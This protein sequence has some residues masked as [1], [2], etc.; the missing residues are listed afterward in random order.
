MIIGKEYISEMRKALD[1]FCDEI[2]RFH[3]EQG[4]NWANDSPAAKEVGGSKGA[5]SLVTAWSHAALLIESGSE[6]LSSFIHAV[7]EPVQPIACWT[8]VRSMLEPCSVSLWLLDPDIDARTRIGRS[9][10]IRY[11]GMD[12]FLKY[13]R[14]TSKDDGFLQP[15][16]DRIREVE[17]EA[18]DLGYPKIRDKT[19]KRRIGIGQRMPSA[20]ELIRMMLNQESMYR[21]LS[22][23]AHGHNWAIRELSYGPVKGK[24]YRSSLGGAPVRMFE[25]TVHPGKIAWLGLISIESI[26]RPVWFRCRYA[27]W[28]KERMKRI[29]D[30]TFDRLKARES[31]RFW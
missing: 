22:A 23:V 4:S 5:A 27:G 24:D 7:E 10:A 19:G 25:K 6:H 8:C 21:L 30:R 9:F 31:L 26:A 12:Q 28:N 16:K 15:I 3:V 11:E 1:E 13:A 14:V 2:H 17:R 29:L 18:L 20:T